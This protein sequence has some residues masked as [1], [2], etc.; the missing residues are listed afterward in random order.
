MKYLKIAIPVVLLTSIGLFY[1]LIPT[2]IT[3]S[4]FQVSNTHDLTATR[5]LNNPAL[6]AKSMAPHYDSNQHKIIIDQIEFTP[7]VAMSNIIE[8]DVATKALQTKSFITANAVTK[9]TAAIH[10]FAEIKTSWNPVQRWKDYQ[11]AVKIKKA[12]A[13]LLKQLNAFVEQPVN[14]QFFAL[15]KAGERG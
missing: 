8:L 10:W 4:T 2:T 13:Q 6:L 3:I 15:Q 7:N 9:E 5:L 1:F 12:T 11:E 14:I